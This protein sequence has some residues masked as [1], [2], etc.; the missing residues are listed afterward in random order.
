MDGREL[1][2]RMKKEMKEGINCS[3]GIRIGGRRK[4]KVLVTFKV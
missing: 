2:L 4:G 3:E 1:S